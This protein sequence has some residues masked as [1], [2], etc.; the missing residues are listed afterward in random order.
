MMESK[1]LILGA[2]GMLGQELKNVFQ[3]D[4]LTCWDKEE[5]DISNR[6]E[7][8]E[9]I[10]KLKPKIII[11]VAAYTNVDE[12]EKNKE[13]VFKINGEAVGFLAE[14]SSK[15]D[16][17]LVHYS[18]DY[19]FDGNKKEGY[20]EDD[21]PKNPLNIYGQ[22]KL[23]GEK[24]LKDNTKKYYLIRTSWLFGRNGKNFVEIILN[25]AQKQKEFKV[26]DD[27][28]GRPTYALDLAKKTKEILEKQKP[29]G[30][31]HVTNK[32]TTNWYEFAKKILEV[33]NINK[34]I[35]LCKSE[36][37]SSPAKRP[38]YS[39]LLNTK[40]DH[41]RN[42]EEALKDYIYESR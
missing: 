38:E 29:F 34:K 1:I 24:L 22:S 40:L 20:K 42:W 25:L 27:Q 11:N 6:D 41:L 19:V 18:T 12:A 10:N 28:Y 2:K 36:E 16:A 5:I 26:V 31:Y 39:I 30:V 23:L 17:I 8:K 7:V 9:K 33:C 15:I 37:F 32:K 4:G 13:L 35:E 21:E 14:V 3:G